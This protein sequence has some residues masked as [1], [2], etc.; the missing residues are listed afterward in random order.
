[1]K[2][3]NL[4]LIQS[5]NSLIS[6]IAENIND[7]GA[8]I[9]NFII[10]DNTNANE[11][12][13]TSTS[14]DD[15]TN[16]HI[17]TIALNV[18]DIYIH[19]TMKNDVNAQ[20]ILTNNSHNGIE[21]THYLN[22][23]HRNRYFKP[24]QNSSL[25]IDVLNQEIDL[26]F[27]LKRFDLYKKLDAI[28]FLYITSYETNVVEAIVVRVGFTF[29]SNLKLMSK[30]TWFDDL[31]KNNVQLQKDYFLD[32]IKL[33]SDTTTY[34]GTNYDIDDLNL[35]KLNI[36][37]VNI[38]DQYVAYNVSDTITDNEIEFIK[39]KCFLQ[40]TFVNRYNSNEKDVVVK[41]LLIGR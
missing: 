9:R 15:G 1:M 6:P 19:E 24:N 5:G 11:P 39:N 16:I 18:D 34:D 10:T 36:S 14:Y 32:S 40:Y 38:K 22:D 28:E 2:T 12:D 41:K 25:T 26:T 23:R 8:Q 20:D 4:K 37:V 7:V 27:L 13:V 30:D 31:F 29:L 35:N 17:S 3:I 21:L 33:I